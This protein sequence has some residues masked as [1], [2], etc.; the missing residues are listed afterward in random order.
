MRS[1][2]CVH[3]IKMATNNGGGLFVFFICCNYMVVQMCWWLQVVNFIV[4]FQDVL[5]FALMWKESTETRSP[6]FAS[7]LTLMFNIMP[8]FFHIYTNFILCLKQSQLVYNVNIKVCRPLENAIKEEF[9]S[10]FTFTILTSS[11]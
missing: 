7:Y 5:T 9:T 2:W 3:V 11:R 1:C 4:V 10:P 6:E 8:F